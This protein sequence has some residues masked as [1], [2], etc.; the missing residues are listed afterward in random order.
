MTSLWS[1][2]GAAALQ[3]HAPTAG[4]ALG[5]L[6]ALWPASISE[7]D[8]ATVRLVAA[9][10]LGLPP[11]PRPL[12]GPRRSA[13]VPRAVVMA[14]AEQF[15]VDVT[16]I[17]DEMRTDWLEAT[18]RDAFDSA[19]AV[20]V[21]DYLPRVRSVLDTLFDG[22][23]GGR[24]G[25]TDAPLVA[26]EKAR[27]LMDEFIHEVAVLDRLDP[28][29]TEL[30]RLRGARQHR[31]RVCM[32]RRSLPAVRAGA[33]AAMFQAVDDYRRSTLTDAQQAALALTDALIWTPADMRASDVDAVRAHLSPAQAVE[34]VLDGMRNAVNKISVA[35]GADSTEQPGVQLF[36]IDEAGRLLFP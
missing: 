24:D 10:G 3:E 23:L 9:E 27:L 2:G 30:V 19:L 6:G 35:L 14:F 1:V 31:C 21:A 4:A 25:W 15:A 16:A 11:L 26:S 12:T 22:P 29:T 20:Y 7:L 17:S 13:E 33:D 5:G 32:A 18:G 8:L 36:E 34:V 28:V